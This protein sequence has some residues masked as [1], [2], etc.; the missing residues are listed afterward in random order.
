MRILHILRHARDERAM[1]T[2]RQQAKEH[3]VTVLLL[4]DAV[5]N[6]PPFEGKVYACLADVEARARR[7][8]YET[9]DYRDIVKLIFESDKVISW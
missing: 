4:H 6:P 2:A 7:A 9:L 5:L 1:A 8:G 3:D